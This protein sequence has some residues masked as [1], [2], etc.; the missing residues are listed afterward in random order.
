ML[1][2]TVNVE[3][4]TAGSDLTRKELLEVLNMPKI[5]IEIFEGDPLKYNSF[6]NVF[7]EKVDRRTS[8][9][10]VKLTR[11]LQYTGGKAKDAI[12]ACALIGG[13]EG[14][15]EAMS[16]LRKRFGNDDLI[17]DIIIKKLKGGSHVRNPSEIEELADEIS[18]AYVTLMGMRR[19][20]E[21]NNQSFILEIASRLPFDMGRRWKREAVNVKCENGKYPDFRHF[22]DYVERGGDR[23]RSS[24]LQFGHEWR[25]SST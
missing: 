6:I 4:D 24:L 3:K 20:D 2:C 13:A 5:E 23:L 14:Y 17:S 16:I 8:D 21:I 25:K 15:P 19:L 11:L 7:K 12:R 9:P 10:W 22:R 1:Y 18:T